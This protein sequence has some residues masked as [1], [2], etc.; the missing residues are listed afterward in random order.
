MQVYAG[1]SAHIVF[2]SWIGEE[3][4]LATCFYAGIEEG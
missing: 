1:M 2:L 3:I 4:G